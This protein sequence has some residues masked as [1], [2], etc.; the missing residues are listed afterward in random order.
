MIKKLF[1]KHE[2]L[3]CIVL[4]LLYVAANSLILQDHDTTEL[5]CALVNT[6]FSAALPVVISLA[7]AAYINK[8]P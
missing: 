8:K 7:Y 6:A 5:S 4:I 3:M 1:A 2:T